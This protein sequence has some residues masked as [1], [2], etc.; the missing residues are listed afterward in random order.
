VTSLVVRRRYAKRRSSPLPLALRLEV[1]SQV[2][3]R[4]TRVAVVAHWSDRQEVSKSLRSLVAAL[5]DMDYHVIVSSAAEVGGPLVWPGGL[6]ERVT[7]YRRE[8]AGYDFGS[9]SSVLRAHS[10]VRS[11]PFVLLAN[12]SLVGPFASIKPLIESFERST[13]PIWGGVRSHQFLPHLQSYLVGYRGGNILR[14]GPIAR[15]WKRVAVQ[16]T[17]TDV[18]WKYELGLPRVLA[19]ARVPVGAMFDGAAISG[20]ANPTI[21]GWRA[22]LDAG[23]PFV[24]RELITNPS[25]APDAAGV[26]DEIRRR[27]GEDVDGWL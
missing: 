12:D 24:K 5:A 21:T 11:A 18:I 17:K 9:W 1:G 25:V 19:R 8:N 27:F 15:F 16:P 22:L 23:F 4:L 26:P 20:E 14:R 13:T 6:P 7:V 10:Q 3:T 2:P